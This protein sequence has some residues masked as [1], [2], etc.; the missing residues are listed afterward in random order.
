MKAYKLIGRVGTVFEYAKYEK[1]RYR[2]IKQLSEA[3]HHN[4]YPVVR[5]WCFTYNMEKWFDGS[6]SVKV[7]GGKCCRK[8]IKEQRLKEN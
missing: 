4:G 3:F 6:L 5:A 8:L 2:V 7:L 1:F